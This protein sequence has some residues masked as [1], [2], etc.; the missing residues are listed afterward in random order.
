MQVDP[1]PAVA[2]IDR[3]IG[4][5]ENND[6]RN[7]PINNNNRG[8]RRLNNQTNPN[9]NICSKEN[10]FR[11][12]FTTSLFLL[13]IIIIATLYQPTQCQF[14]PCF[15]V[16]RNHV[17]TI[18]RILYSEN[19]CRNVTSITENNLE[20]KNTLLKLELCTT[21]VPN[22][23]NGQIVMIVTV[24]ELLF[25]TVNNNH[26]TVNSGDKNNYYQNKLPEKEQLFPIRVTVNDLDNTIKDA[27]IPL[28]REIR[29]NHKISKEYQFI[30]EVLDGVLVNVRTDFYPHRKGR[31]LE[32]TNF[33]GTNLKASPRTSRDKTGIVTPKFNISRKNGDVMIK[34]TISLDDENDDY[35]ELKQ[36]GFNK[37]NIK[38]KITSETTFEEKKNYVGE[39]KYNTSLIPRHI[40]EKE[41]LKVPL[42]AS[43]HTEI[44]DLK[45]S[46]LEKNYWNKKFSEGEKS[47]LLDKCPNTPDYQVCTNKTCDEEDT[48]DDYTEK[49]QEEGE[50]LKKS[51]ENEKFNF[52]NITTEN[53]PTNGRN[54][55]TKEICGMNLQ[56]GFTTAVEEKTN[57]P[58]ATVVGTSIELVAQ[59]YANLCLHPKV[60]EKGVLLQIRIK[61]FK[62]KREYQTDTVFVLSELWYNGKRIGYLIEKKSTLYPVGSHLL[63]WKNVP[64]RKI[65]NNRRCGPKV[66]QF[67]G[68]C[69]SSHTHFVSGR[70]NSCNYKKNGEDVGMRCNRKNGKIRHCS[71]E[72]ARR[73]CRQFLQFHKMAGECCQPL[74]NTPWNYDP[75]LH[76]KQDKEWLRGCAGVFKMDD[77][78]YKRDSTC[79]VMRDLQRIG[80]DWLTLTDDEWLSIKNEKPAG[81]SDG[82]KPVRFV[83]Q[84]CI[85][86]TAINAGFKTY[87]QIGSRSINLYSQ[88]VPYRR[89]RRRLVDWRADLL[90]AQFPVPGVGTLKLNIYIRIWD[91]QKFSLV[92][93]DNI[94]DNFDNSA[95]SDTVSASLEWAIRA[96]IGGAAG[97]EILGMAQFGV[98]FTGKFL[99]EALEVKIEANN[100]KTSMKLKEIKGETYI[101]ADLEGQ[102]L[103]CSGGCR[104]CCWCWFHCWWSGMRHIANLYYVKLSKPTEKI[105]LN[106]QYQ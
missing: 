8:D 27:E 80:K 96:Q 67:L 56:T 46:H 17:P 47:S 48:K 3:Q 39:S 32:D 100:K 78:K 75:E 62:S 38:I 97:I 76:L 83:V 106:I 55:A 30:L 68:P 66:L 16:G 104:W 98:K 79:E 31:F 13:F 25:G 84:N 88:T 11:N 73:D 23:N 54:L 34:E 70:L 95:G 99:Q 64:Q 49:I 45:P 15:A 102:F 57:T 60:M 36:E 1:N 5:R 101:R 44:S 52:S 50:T 35:V 77:G 53:K 85:Q 21:E 33:E 89:R 58:V 42:Q 92:G 24:K 93:N 41:I 12:I 71:C 65:D 7:D 18:F 105:L 19:T 20:K 43:Y 74:T 26:F 4:D 14:Y 91:T 6:Q 51:V 9:N 81:A 72:P 90:N 86:D 69:C 10:R 59:A 82:K 94:P 37:N 40:D 29:C 2:I 103:R 28:P 87:L 61:E 22:K 63:A